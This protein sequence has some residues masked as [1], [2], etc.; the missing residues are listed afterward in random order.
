VIF[1]EDRQKEIHEKGFDMGSGPILDYG[2]IKIGPKYFEN[3]ALVMDTLYTPNRHSF[4][5]KNEV[6]RALA[7][8]NIPLLRKMSNHF[9]NTSGLYR[10]MCHYYAFM[11]RYDWYVASEILDKGVNVE[12]VEKDFY[13]LLNYLDNS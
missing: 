8:G 9:Y 1:L 10:N 6:I 2:G 13:K 4:Y 5:T 11:Y 12:K 3:T 7:E